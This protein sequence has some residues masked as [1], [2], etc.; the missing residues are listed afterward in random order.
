MNKAITK[1][2]SS[3]IVLA[4]LCFAAVLSSCK[5]ENLTVPEPNANIRPAADFIRNNYDFKIFYAALEYTGI[6]Q[7]LNGTGPF[8]ILALPDA[9]FNQEGI[10][11]A[12][13]VQ[14]LNKDSLR[15]VLKYHI[16][17]GRR[18]LTTDVPTNAIDLRYQTMSGN[19]LYLSSVTA[20]KRFFFSGSLVTRPD[21]TLANGVLH[22]LVKMMKYHKGA[23]V[24]QFLEKNRR[25]SIYVTGLKKFGLWNDLAGEGPF[26]VFAPTDS[27]FKANDI[28]AADIEVLNPAGYNGRRLFGAYIMRQKHFFI[29][30]KFVFKNIGGEYNYEIAIPNDTWI[31]RFGTD[32]G[33]PFPVTNMPFPQLTLLNPNGQFGLTEMGRYWPPYFGSALPAIA[34][35]DHLCENGVVHDIPGLM[36]L[37]Q[38]AINQ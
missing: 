34:G 33:Y 36:L 9:A 35:F 25:Y 8:T 6:A 31:V 28:T 26:T 22:V 2:T 37:P 20:D 32:E 12:A 4:I 15:R 5:H 27:A 16:L 13:D 18:L 19:E 3:L 17:K 23:T 10:T 29:S 7:E 1:Y 21:V 38:Q 14:R 11:S 30:D 24:Q